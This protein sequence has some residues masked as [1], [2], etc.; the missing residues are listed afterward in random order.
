MG[1]NLPTAT[2][3]IVGYLDVDVRPCELKVKLP[4]PYISDV[5]V[6]INHRRQGLARKLIQKGEQF[7]VYA[8]QQQKEKKKEDNNHELFTTTYTDVWIRVEETN[9]AALELYQNRLGY[10]KIDWCTSTGSYSELTTSN[11]DTDTDITNVAS[12]ENNNDNDV[13]TFMNTVAK[14]ISTFKGK[15]APKILTLRKRIE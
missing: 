5:V 2:E 12:S 8:T 1:D 9:T 14:G 4:R 11:T 10:V 13:S 15:E 6:D 7:I 3:L